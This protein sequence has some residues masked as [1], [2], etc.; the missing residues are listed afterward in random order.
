[1]EPEPHDLVEIWRGQAKHTEKGSTGET[2]RE[3]RGEAPDSKHLDEA[4]IARRE[5]E[6]PGREKPAERNLSE[7]RDRRDREGERI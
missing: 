4:P 3:R 1:M 2:K 5:R 7:K 6:V